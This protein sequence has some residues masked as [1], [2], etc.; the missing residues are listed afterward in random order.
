MRRVK[1]NARYITQYPCR[2]PFFATTPFYQND[3]AF[4]H[5]GLVKLEI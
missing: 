4:S 1:I 5:A 3:I 2:S